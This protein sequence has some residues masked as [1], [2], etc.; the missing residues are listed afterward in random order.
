M[1]VREERVKNFYCC[2]AFYQLF[3]CSYGE[4]ANVAVCAVQDELESLYVPHWIL[5]RVIVKCLVAQTGSL[6]KEAPTRKVD[7][8]E[9]RR[10]NL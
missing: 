7:G 5:V 9:V 6:A 2:G 4:N 1:W 3:A 8:S 10:V